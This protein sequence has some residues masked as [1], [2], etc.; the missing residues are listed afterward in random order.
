MMPVTRRSVVGGRLV[1]CARNQTLNLNR[2]QSE[3]QHQ[4][5]LAPGPHDLLLSISV[6]NQPRSVREDFREHAAH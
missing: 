1:A 4:N 2:I 6:F 5:D 3:R